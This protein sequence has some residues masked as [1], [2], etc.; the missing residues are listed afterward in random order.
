M[1]MYPCVTLTQW[2]PWWPSDL[3][4][5]KMINSYILSHY[6]CGHLL[7]KQKKTNN[8]PKQSYCQKHIPTG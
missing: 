1:C 5:C 4:N 7:Q 8:F 6:I 3:Q 2:D